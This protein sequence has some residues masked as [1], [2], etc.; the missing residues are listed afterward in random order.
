MF[1]IIC[2]AFLDGNEFRLTLMVEKY[3]LET[4]IEAGIKTVSSSPLSAALEHNVFTRRLQLG[5]PCVRAPGLKESG[6][7]KCQTVYR[8]LLPKYEEEYIKLECSQ[9]V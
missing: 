2:G 1:L 7:L 8:S 9:N 6:I 3:S 5:T 4:F